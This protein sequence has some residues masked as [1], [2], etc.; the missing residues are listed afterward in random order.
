MPGGLDAFS[1]DGLATRATSRRLPDGLAPCSSGDI[2]HAVQSQIDRFE[3]ALNNLT[4]GVCFFDGSRRLI[5]ANRRYADIYQ[6]SQEAILPG[7]TLE[8]IVDLR[9]VAGPAPI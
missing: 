8:E 5:L 9:F 7:M 2:P 6:L 4:Q 3:V 1:M